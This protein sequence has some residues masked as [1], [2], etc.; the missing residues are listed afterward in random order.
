MKVCRVKYARV[1]TEPYSVVTFEHEPGLT[2]PQLK[3]GISV[4]Q[5]ET[6]ERWLILCSQA[7]NEKNPERLLELISE[8]N[9]M[10]DE[11]ERRVKPRGESHK[12]CARSSD[13]NVSNL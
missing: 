1:E 7:A 6:R 11:K 3:G 10:L 12:Y 8:I 13:L 5:G 2:R 9:Q 4:M